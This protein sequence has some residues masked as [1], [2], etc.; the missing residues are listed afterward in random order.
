MLKESVNSFVRVSPPRPQAPLPGRARCTLR[1][2]IDNS[3]IAWRCGTV[4]NEKGDAWQILFGFLAKIFGFLSKAIFALVSTSYVNE[5]SLEGTW[6]LLLSTC[7]FSL[8]F[9]SFLLLYCAKSSLRF[10]WANVG[11]LPQIINNN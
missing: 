11:P 5:S 1:Y 8:P 2:G 10:S 9:G 3:Q 4:A 6:K 7:G